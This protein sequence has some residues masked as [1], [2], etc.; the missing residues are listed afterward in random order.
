GATRRPRPPP[1]F[2]LPSEPI[3][4]ARRHEK[5]R[6]PPRPTMVAKGSRA[7]AA[8]FLNGLP[9]ELDA[10]AVG[11]HLLDDVPVDLAD[12]VA[13]D[14]RQAVPEREVDG[15]VDLLVEER[16]AHV[17]R[18]AGVA[19]DHELPEAPGALVDVELL[20]QEVLVHLRRGVDDLAALEAKPDPAH[21]A[22]GVDRRELAEHDL[23]LGGVLPR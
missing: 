15:P 6:L 3:D 20:D 4:L 7:P 9:V 1:R 21:L 8:G 11:A 19:A 2:F 23:A 13:P 12:V 22:A 17:P 5:T 18:D 10:A 16:V 14:L